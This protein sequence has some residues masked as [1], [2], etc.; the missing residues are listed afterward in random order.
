MVGVTN[1]F[2]LTHL[3]PPPFT[4]ARKRSAAH[5]TDEDEDNKD[6]IYYFKIYSKLFFSSYLN[7]D[8]MKICKFP[9][10]IDYTLIQ[11]NFLW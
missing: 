1:T 9:K 11:T 4:N 8:S 6:L 5:F 2:L 10:Y 3:L 7:Y